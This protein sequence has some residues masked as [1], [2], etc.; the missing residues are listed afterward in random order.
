MPKV[1][2]HFLKTNGLRDK[3]VRHLSCEGCRKRKMKCSRTMPCASCEMRGHDCIWLDCKPAHGAMQATVEEN[4]T[5]IIRLEKIVRQLQALIIERDG[6]PYFPPIVA[7]PT[8]PYTLDG[9]ALPSPSRSHAPRFYEVPGHSAQNNV[10]PSTAQSWISPTR[11]TSSPSTDFPSY[12]L[13]APPEVFGGEYRP[14]YDATVSYATLLAPPPEPHAQAADAASPDWSQPHSRSSTWASSATAYAHHAGDTLFRPV[15][16]SSPKEYRVE[17]ESSF[18]RAPRDLPPLDTCVA[19]APGP[20][21]VSALLNGASDHRV[22]AEAH[23]LDFSVEGAKE[24]QTEDRAGWE[25]L[26]VLSGEQP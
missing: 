16:S 3:N 21:T 12:P 11:W 24:G 17:Q 2:A 15:P 8:P 23:N 1:Q 10:S 20:S 14:S 7:P 5:E 6:R 26:M 18:R 13:P 4:Q 22:T 9:L 19:R 25:S